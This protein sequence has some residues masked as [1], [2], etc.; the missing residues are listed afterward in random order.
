MILRML[1]R[2]E[3]NEMLAD[4]MDISRRDV[5]RALELKLSNNSASLDSYIH[6]LNGIQA[7]YG[8]FKYLQNPHPTHNNR[9]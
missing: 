9:L 7:V 6:F 2:E 5:F 1:N 3:K 4:A 8:P